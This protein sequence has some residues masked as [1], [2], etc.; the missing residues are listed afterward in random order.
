VISAYTIFLAAIL[1]SQADSPGECAF[2]IK[3]VNRCEDHV[4]NRWAMYN[5]HLLPDGR[6]KYG[7]QQY[8]QP[9]ATNE[10]GFL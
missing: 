3:S 10:A 4:L 6:Q 5:R 1:V 8:R 2:W 7:E 9:R